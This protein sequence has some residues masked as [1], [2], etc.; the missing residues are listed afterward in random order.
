MARL[1]VLMQET[2]WASSVPQNV[3]RERIFWDIGNWF[4]KTRKVE[5]SSMVTQQTILKVR[6]LDQSHLD[7]LRQDEDVWLPY[8]KKALGMR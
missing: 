5:A 2:G 6:G 1:L 8:F 4:P 3:D 7:H